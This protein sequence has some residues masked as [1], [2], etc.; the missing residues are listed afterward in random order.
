MALHTSSSAAAAASYPEPLPEYLAYLGWPL[1]II[2]VCAAVLFWRDPK[3]R[4]AAVTFALLEL[5]SLGAVTMTF[6]GIRYPASFLPW[7]WLQSVPILADVLPDRF[8]ILAD[9]AAGALLAFAL[10]RAREPVPRTRRGRLTGLVATAVVVLATL[11]LVPLPLPATSVGQPPAGWQATFG[12]LRLAADAHVLVIPDI[13]L[14]S[15]WQAETGV[16]ASM[17]GGGATVEPDRTGQA[18][19]YIYNRL[20]TT[21]Y[22]YALWQGAPPG[23]AP[24]QSQIRGDLAYWRLAAIVTVTSRSSRLARFLTGEFG[25][26]TVQL[27]SVLAWR[28]PR[29]RPAAFGNHRGA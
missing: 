8:S 14:P 7:H 15:R 23:R 18:T 22:L 26:P 28:S 16:P 29:L 17:V 20:S 11:P 12:R 21:Q 1:L 6:H 25:P 13:Q 2:L 24:S 27:G 4:L 5:F 3:V 10:D 9:G 19:S